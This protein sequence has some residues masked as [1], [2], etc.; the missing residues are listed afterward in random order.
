MASG[1]I[2]VC[3]KVT[4]KY[5]CSYSQILLEDSPNGLKIPH[6]GW[7]CTYAKALGHQDPP[8]L[9]HFRC[10]GPVLYRNI[11]VKSNNI[12]KYVT[13]WKIVNQ[14]YKVILIGVIIP[15]VAFDIISGLCMDGR[16]PSTRL[17]TLCPVTQLLSSYENIIYDWNKVIWFCL[18]MLNKDSHHHLSFSNVYLRS[19]KS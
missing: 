10:I 17:T 18:H 14:L 11:R 3:V 5:Q 7:F 15:N 9:L 13:F 6:L 12:R 1:W 16:T 19:W 2:E 4:Q 8:D